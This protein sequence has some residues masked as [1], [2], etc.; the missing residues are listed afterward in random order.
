[1]QWVMQHKNLDNKYFQYSS[2]LIR[3]LKSNFNAG[4]LLI[5][6]LVHLKI[7][8][9]LPSLSKII[10]SCHKQNNNKTKCESLLPYEIQI[11]VI[12][13]F[14]VWIDRSDDGLCVLVRPEVN[15]WER[16]K[17]HV[18]HLVNPG[19]WRPLDGRVRG[20]SSDSDSIHGH[21]LCRG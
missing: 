15:S 19:C 1:M 5:I 14:T 6:I 18:H 9:L 8:V 16:D 13:L 12:H 11:L 20:F 3:V 17:L 7:R 21:D 4:L 2:L 10:D